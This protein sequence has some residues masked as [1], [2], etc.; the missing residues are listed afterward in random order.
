VAFGFSC[1]AH[2]IPETQIVRLRLTLQNTQ[3]YPGPTRIV[4]APANFVVK[5]PQPV[6]HVPFD[7]GLMVAPSPAAKTTP[8]PTK[9]P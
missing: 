2:A 7:P 9:K 1:P 5:C 3:W 4:D 8:P 6:A